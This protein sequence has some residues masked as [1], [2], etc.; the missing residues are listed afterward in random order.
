[1]PLSLDKLSTDELGQWGERAAQFWLEKQGYHLVEKNYR[2]RF[3]EIDLIMRHAGAVVFIEVKTRRSGAHSQA[4]WAVDHKK[5]RRLRMTTQDYIAQRGLGG[6]MV[7]CEV[8]TVVQHG[9]W[10]RIKKFP[11]EI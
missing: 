5:R 7:Q 8:V 1:M 9:D 3:G 6:E 10:I 2:T 4:L 11:L